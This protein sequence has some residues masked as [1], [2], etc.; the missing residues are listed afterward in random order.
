MALLVPYPGGAD[1][2]VDLGI[3]GLPAEFCDGFFAAGNQKSRVT[4]AAGMDFYGDGV[5]G[6]PADRVDDFLDSEAGAVAQVVDQ[7]VIGGAVGFESFQGQEMGIGQ[8]ADVNVIAD[9][10]AVMCGVVVAKNLDGFAAS[11]GNVQNQRNDV[12]L[13]LVGFA[14]IHDAAS[15]AAGF[16]SSGD[17][18][19]AERG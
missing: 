19:V 3:V 16:R 5:A 8:V 4:G 15:M 12:R 18:E 11:E 6:D 1:D 10:G 14:A 2:V 9:A 17:I 13:R 7:P